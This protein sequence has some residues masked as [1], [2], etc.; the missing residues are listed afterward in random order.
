MCVTAAWPI[1]TDE[2]INMSSLLVHSVELEKE[3][4]LI[5]Y[6]NINNNYDEEGFLR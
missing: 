4:L 2:D 3:I 6:Q 5:F 1:E